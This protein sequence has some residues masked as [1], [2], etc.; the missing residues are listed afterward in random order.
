M[1]DA[2]MCG[3]C[4]N[5]EDS[6]EHRTTCVKYGPLTQAEERDQYQR[7]ISRLLKERHLLHGALVSIADITANTS[8]IKDARVQNANR[9]ANEAIRE[10]KLL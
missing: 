1:T 5:R 6:D 2:L 4:G 7:R 10:A 8:L 9:I 3:A